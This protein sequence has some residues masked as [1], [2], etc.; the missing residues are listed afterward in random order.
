LSYLIDPKLVVYKSTTA[1]QRITFAPVEVDSIEELRR[2]LKRHGNY[3]MKSNGYNRK[4]KSGRRKS[5]T[6]VRKNSYLRSNAI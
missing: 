6:A 4:R 3:K 5:A 2:R 1:P